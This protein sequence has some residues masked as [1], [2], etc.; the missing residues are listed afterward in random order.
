MITSLA[1]RAAAIRRARFEAVLNKYDK[2]QSVSLR[3]HQEPTLSACDI[4]LSAEARSP[5]RSAEELRIRAAFKISTEAKAGER[6]CAEASDISETFHSEALKMSTV[7]DAELVNWF[8][9]LS[10]EQLPTPPFK[11][12]Q[13]ATVMGTLFY[14]QLRKSIEAGY[15]SSRARTG[16]LQGDLKKLRELMSEENINTVVNVRQDDILDI[17]N[18]TIKGV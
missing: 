14:E 17:E 2:G 9:S 7:E 3:E 12:Y 15:S 8:L 10:P 4:E 6:V 1:E 16:A 11:L 18:V 13:H 5:K